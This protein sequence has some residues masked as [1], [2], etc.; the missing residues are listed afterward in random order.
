MTS[1]GYYTRIL[2]NDWNEV[3]VHRF[4]CLLP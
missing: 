1:V 3:V 4:V 2:V